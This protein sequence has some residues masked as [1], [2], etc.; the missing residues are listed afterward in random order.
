MEWE[1][2]IILFISTLVLIFYD[3]KIKGAL[4]RKARDLLHLG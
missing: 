4:G 3:R 2:P 1:Y